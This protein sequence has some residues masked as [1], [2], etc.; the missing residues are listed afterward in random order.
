MHAYITERVPAS[1]LASTFSLLASV[2]SVGFVISPTLGGI[3][4]DRWGIRTTLMVGFVLFAI[5]TALVLRMDASGPGTQPVTRAQP[6]SAGDLRPVLSALVI[7]V[8][9]NAGVLITQPFIYPFLREARG[10]SLSYIGVLSSA[11]AV[12]AVTLAP[13][14]G[15]IADRLGAVRALAGAVYVNGAGAL[16]TSVGPASLLPLGAALRC[17]APLNSL[18]QAHLATQAPPAVL[19]R[20][21]ALAGVS[22]ALLA[23]VTSFLGG[24]AYRADPVYPLLIAVAIS[25][26]LGPI[27]AWVSLRARRR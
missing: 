14:A 4:A 7:Y 19:G 5:S 9:V 3:I 27:L 11:Q 15:R 2:T 25:A 21:F 17:R 18:A 24:F 26:V 12:G 10:A 16:L 20:T 22:S 23:A 13:L 6:M 1:E 8:A